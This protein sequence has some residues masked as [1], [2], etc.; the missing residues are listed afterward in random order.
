MPRRRTPVDSQVDGATQTIVTCYDSAGEVIDGY[1]ITIEAD[2][3]DGDGTAT[4]PDLFP[5]ASGTVT[6]SCD[7]EI[8]P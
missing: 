6:V 4:L 3:D 8:D 1:P 5:T 2:E 7:F